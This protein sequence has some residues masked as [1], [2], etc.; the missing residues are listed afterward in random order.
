MKE[1]VVDKDIPI[2]EVK[3]RKLRENRYPWRAL[4]IGDSFVV[5]EKD[6]R[7]VRCAA[8]HFGRRLGRKFTT[9]TQSNGQVRVWR[10]E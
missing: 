4:S 6:K 8:C 3:S 10:I 1:F 7:S 5:E 9:R 2:P